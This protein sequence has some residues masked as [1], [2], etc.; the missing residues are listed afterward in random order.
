MYQGQYYD[1]EIGLA[2]N[3]FRYYD[4]E[5]GRY[6]SQDPIG[7]HS[8]EYGLYNYVGDPNG[9]ID[10]F[11]LTKSYTEAEAK[12]VAAKKLQETLDE[13][14]QLSNNKRKDITTVV[15]GVNMET[16]EVA[17]GKKNSKIHASDI[18]A[19]DLVVQQ[20]GGDA[21]KIKMTEAIR[22]RNKDVIDVCTKC[23]GNYPK[24]SFF[25]NVKFQ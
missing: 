23:Q 24:D 16:G 4:A 14:D 19:E 6:I 21:S 7:L 2:Y 5:N 3:R 13:L 1:E 11:G 10:V 9:W 18:C 17:V 20:L 8:G 12:E 22:P 15:V 25:D